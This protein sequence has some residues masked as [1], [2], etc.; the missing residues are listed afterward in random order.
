MPQFLRR[1]IS[2]QTGS[3]Q[4]DAL[5]TTQKRHRFFPHALHVHEVRSEAAIGRDSDCVASKHQL[6][7]NARAS[8]VLFRTPSCQSESIC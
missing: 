3:E 5:D 7:T 1:G 4:L 6:I 8:R 2:K